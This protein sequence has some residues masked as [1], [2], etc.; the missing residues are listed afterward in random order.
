M[1]Y[2][3]YNACHRQRYS[4]VIQ[5]HALT[6]TEKKFNIVYSMDGV[7]YVDDVRLKRLSGRSC[8]YCTLIVISI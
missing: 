2:N 3:L 5:G 6:E 7:E 8:T 1:L 4:H